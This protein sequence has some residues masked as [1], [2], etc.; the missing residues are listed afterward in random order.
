MQVFR[1]FLSATW[2]Y[3]L[4]ITNCKMLREWALTNHYEFVQNCQLKHACLFRK[5][6]YTEQNIFWH[7]PIT[8]EF[9]LPLLPAFL[10]ITA[11][12]KVQRKLKVSD[13][14]FEKGHCFASILL[15]YSHFIAMLLS[16]FTTE[17]SLTKYYFLLNE[18]F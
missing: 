4:A 1:Q 2:W 12:Q 11:N 13:R 14:C 16:D 8:F 9:C 7:C 15:L 10:L 18:S 17:N 6:N 3:F 5:T